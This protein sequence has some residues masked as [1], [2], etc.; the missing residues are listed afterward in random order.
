MEKIKLTSKRLTQEYEVET[1]IQEGENRQ[2]VILHTSLNKIFWNMPDD[3]RP[4][5]TWSIPDLRNLPGIPP[6]F[7][8][9]CTLSDGNV[10]IQETG[11]L[12]CIEWE[13]GDTIKKR[14][15]F[16]VCENRAFDKAFI[17]YMQFEAKDITYAGIYSSAEI[18]FNSRSV[19]IP[20]SAPA[21]AP[22]YAPPQTVSAPANQTP[23]Q[24]QPVTAPATQ[25]PAPPKPQS[26]GVSNPPIPNMPAPMTGVRNQTANNAAAPAPAPTPAQMPTTNQVQNTAP[27]TEEPK[28]R[29]RKPKTATE[30]AQ[31]AAPSVTPPPATTPPTPTAPQ[32]GVAGLPWLRGMGGNNGQATPPQPSMPTNTP[33]VPSAQNTAPAPA[34][35]NADG[36]KQRDVYRVAF[37]FLSGCSNVETDCGTFRYNQQENRW[38]P[39]N[40]ESAFNETDL[41][42]LYSDAS[43]MIGTELKNFVGGLNF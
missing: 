40:N 1:F 43:A 34:P 31:S 42:K 23:V 14:N 22:S 38:Y 27:A 11:E 39:T 18:E 33:P 20:A 25:M 36:K 37:D 21:T 24:H 16:A 12:T 2:L 30:P 41:D 3:K 10:S 6:M 4:K 35:A 32:R 13:Q 15:P 8:K 7:V 26:T 19:S 5:I 29:G 28:K 9:E 17:R